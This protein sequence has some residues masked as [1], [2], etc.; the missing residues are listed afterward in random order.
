MKK[1]DVTN[2]FS[3]GIRPIVQAEMGLGGHFSR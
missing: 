3:C 2:L 1:D